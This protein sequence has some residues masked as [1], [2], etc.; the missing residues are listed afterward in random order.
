MPTH[1]NSG[2]SK[3]F[4]LAASSVIVATFASLGMTSAAAATGRDLAAQSRSVDGVEV[5]VSGRADTASTRISVQLTTH[6]R[7]LGQ[8]LD[9]S[10]LQAATTKLKG[11]KWVG[12]PATGHHRS[13]TLTFQGRIPNGAPIS[14]SLSGWNKPLVFRWRPN[15]QPLL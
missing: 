6:A 1:Q 15:G 2:S 12:D 13:G 8:N 10:K 3:L 4:A 9:A 11:A 7:E 14:L 5:V